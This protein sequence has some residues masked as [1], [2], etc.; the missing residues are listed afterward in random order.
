MGMVVAGGKGCFRFQ[1][2]FSLSSL[3]PRNLIS[4]LKSKLST[5][6]N[7]ISLSFHPCS[8][9]MRNPKRPG[10]SLN[11]QFNVTTFVSPDGLIFP[12]NNTTVRSVEL[13]VAVEKEQKFGEYVIRFISK[14]CHSYLHPLV[15]EPVVLWPWKICIY[16]IVTDSITTS[17]SVVSQLVP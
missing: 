14:R 16:C 13:T 9:G 10:I 6:D 15:S 1:I 8:W 3:Y 4:P 7:I 11:L 17:Q 2:C 12:F 5:P